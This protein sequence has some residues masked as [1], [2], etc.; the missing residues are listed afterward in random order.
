[1]RSTQISYRRQTPKKR[2]YRKKYQTRMEQ[3]EHRLVFSSSNPNLSFEV[4]LSAESNSSNTYLTT[5]FAEAVAD[6]A[7]QIHSITLGDNVS[8]DGDQPSEFSASTNAAE[9][10]ADLVFI[11][12]SGI[13]LE[14]GTVP[15][16]GID[17]ESGTVY[18]YHS[19]G[20]DSFVALSQDGGVNFTNSQTL[21]N[22][23][24]DPRGLIM[25]QVDEN[26]R[27]IWR[28]YN[29]EQNIFASAISYDGSHYSREDGIRF[30]PPNADIIGVY[31]NY[32]TADNRVALMYIGDKGTSEASVRLAYSTDNGETFELY[33]DNPLNDLGTHD[34]GL[35]QR[36]P[37]ANVWEDGRIRIFTMVQGGP[38]APLPG[39]RAVTQ[40]E[41]FTSTDDGLTFAHDPGIRLSP[42]D[43]TEFDVWSLNDPSVIQLPDGRYRLYVAALITETPDAADPRWVI[44]SATAS[45]EDPTSQ[46]G[47]ENPEKITVQKLDDGSL[48]C[49]PVGEGPFP[50]VLYNH[51]GLGTAV[52][53]DLQ[54]TC[55]ALAEAGY[56]ARSE[57]RPPSVSLDGQLE[58]VLQ[59]LDQLR[60]H[61]DVD[62]ERVAIAGFS[63]GG[64]LAL[65]AAIARPDEIDAVLLFAPAPGRGAMDQTLLNV[66]EVQAPVRIHIA[67][68]DG[69]LPLAQEV[70]SALQNAGKDVELIVYSA[71]EDD[72]HDLFDEVREPYWS[73]VLAFLSG[74]FD[75]STEKS[76]FV[77]NEAVLGR[78]DVDNTLKGISVV[79][80][81][82][83]QLGY[84]T[85]IMT[86]TVS[87]VD[88]DTGT[89]ERTFYLTDHAQ[90]TKKLAFDPIHRQLWAVANKQD[91][92]L[93][94]VDPDTGTVLDSRDIGEDFSEQA[95]S[96]PIRD[97]TVDPQSQQL[98]TLISDVHGNR[99]V[100]YDTS[101]QIV[102]ELLVGRAI[103]DLEW[104]VEHNTLIALS[105]PAPN[106]GQ[107]AQV[108]LLPNGSEADQQKFT[109]DVTSS[110]SNMPPAKIAVSESGDLFLA[111]ETNL[112]KIDSTNGTVIWHTDL[113]FQ[114][115]EL[116][117]SGDQVGVLHQY[118][119][120]ASPDIFISRLSTYNTENGELIAIRKGRFEASR[121]DATTQGFLVGNGG[122]ASVSIFPADTTEPTNIQVGSAAE[123]VLV[124]PDGNRMLVLNRLGGSQLIE[125]NLETGASRVLDTVPWP[126]RMVQRPQD[127]RLFIFSHFAPTV[128]VRDLETLEVLG[129]ISLAPHGVG[130]SYSDTLSDMSADPNGDLL[131]A[132][133]CEQGKV[134]IIDGATQSVLAVVNLGGLRRND[135]PGRMNAAVDLSDP[136]NR[137]VFVFL[138][139]DNT[140]YRLEES[141]DFLPHLE[142]SVSVPVDQ[143]VQKTYGFRSVYYSPAIDKVFVWN[144]AVDPDTLIVESEV[145]GVERLV[146]EAAGV[147]YGQHKAPAG[148]N[149]TESLVTFDATTFETTHKQILAETMAMDVK[150]H[151][152]LSHGRVAFTRPAYSEA[153]L[154][155]IESSSSTEI[156]IDHVST[157]Q[158]PVGTHRPEI[159]A[160]ESGEMLAIVVQPGD[161][162]AGNRIKHQVYRYD[163]DGNQIGETFPVTWIT[164]E[165]GEPA[166]HRAAIVDD[167]LVI[168]YQSLV[169]DGDIAVGGG[170][171]EQYALNQSLLMARY[172]LDGQELFRG[173]IV[174]H[175][176]DFSEDNF[177]DHCL[178]PL[179][180]SLLVST[181]A[182]QQIKLR[183]VS[184]TGEVLNSYEFNTQPMRSLA[185]IG[186][187]LL[188]HDDRILM[189]TGTGL[190][191]NGE[192]GIS[193]L[194][195]DAAYQPTELAWFAGEDQEYTFPTGALSY[196]GYTFVTYDARE[197][198]E[199]YLS[200][201]EH[202]F[203]P[204][205]VV[206]DADLAMVLN[207]SIGSGPGFAHVHPT[208]NIIGDQL[209]IG[210]SMQAEMEGTLHQ[211][212]QVQLERYD[213][214]FA[215][216]ESLQLAVWNGDAPTGNTG[217]GI[218]WSDP[219][220][221]T[222]GDTVD[223][224]PTATAPGGNVVFQKAPTVGT[225]LLGADRVVNSL[226]FQDDY[227]LTGHVLTV[228]SGI[229]NVQEDTTA[230]ITAM[231]ASNSGLTKSGTGTLIVTTTSSELVVDQGILVLPKS[232]SIEN[233]KIDSGATAILNG[234]VQ[235][236]FVNN[237]L[238]QIGKTP[239]GD[240]ATGAVHVSSQ[241]DTPEI[242]GDFD[243]VAR[244]VADEQSI[245]AQ[246]LGM[247]DNQEDDVDVLQVNTSQTPV[248]T[249]KQ[250][251]VIGPGDS[252]L[253]HLSPDPR[254]AQRPS[255][256]ANAGPKGLI[257]NS[258][259]SNGSKLTE[260]RNRSQIRSHCETSFT[261]QTNRLLTRHSETAT[262]SARP[263]VELSKVARSLPVANIDELM[264]QRLD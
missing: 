123:D 110:S 221:W 253:T 53:G 212:P 165:Y 250:G 120:P 203:R 62:P 77:L 25:P 139:D 9:L 19:I 214:T 216:D 125:F 155:G 260:S 16:V 88:L 93:W 20:P 119:A 242:S 8:T 141:N 231:L 63:R 228:T 48:E 202:P 263:R 240:T 213:L 121:M 82:E 140:L 246:F 254:V 232:G 43:F 99:V 207:M 182:S 170:P 122:D 192:N 147:L 218:R 185:S 162:V 222:T 150:V 235:G 200:P 114:T 132:L 51:G 189:I 7:T 175:V 241:E 167:E 102:D 134:A 217:D 230:A 193:V 143:Q 249:T 74:Q 183:Q 52:G 244:Q 41:S 12:D 238:L 64:L 83:R 210:W 21:T 172:S 68:N 37:A 237:G 34:D 60:S 113:P 89:L 66:S 69:L 79:A 70:D 247:A 220:N 84:V 129:E 204:N 10:S 39:K 264:A 126:V 24:F 163:A 23:A 111:G 255:A 251:V 152:D 256:Q 130:T 158:M 118:G 100:V 128:E 49:R 223:E 75:A 107:P 234:T 227:H 97:V 168:V 131:V 191:P 1:M 109:P 190:G 136:D 27:T 15:E 112:W 85:G 17:P 47:E 5:E 206:L 176:T 133:Q 72:G 157:V 180:D 137:Q 71:F 50:A 151:L 54:G 178:L 103:V 76:Y 166:D 124:T 209:I 58:D 117:V 18:L 108:F 22:R 184:Y 101:L 259:E 116:A 181:G 14:G 40:I 61:P 59:G 4:D 38:H 94:L 46:P 257:V 262:L 205:L 35:N 142:A 96:Y 80:D 81:N 57:Q 78:S 258:L 127:G 161:D 65:Q 106:T 261:Q 135:G 153:H 145:E 156:Q 26:G 225:V 154:V 252:N 195:L 160:T 73:Q 92:F 173:P 87:V 13:R 243:L 194:E 86:D 196:K 31:T 233:L 164:E 199:T 42:A 215:Q 219:N 236:D 36:D 28:K 224:L 188:N 6:S 90:A 245:H 138:A 211:A 33:D 115:T 201:K 55:E 30:D 179:E 67:E 186:N 229:I 95:N 45:L 248:E 11:P 208:L 197:D 3:L 98:Y 239:E 32:I 104:D 105:A 174:A 171:S 226:T 44:V 56:F 146:G 149:Q 169:Y 29:L 187:S 144:V 2:T 148:V 198:T 91:A 177:P 159:L